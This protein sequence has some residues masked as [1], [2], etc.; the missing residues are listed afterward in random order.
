MHIICFLFVFFCLAW[1]F[2]DS[3]MLLHIA[4]AHSFS[5]F[6]LEF[7]KSKNQLG[8][9]FLGFTVW[10]VFFLGNFCLIQGHKYF[11]PMASF[12]SVILSGFTFRF[13]I[14]LEIIFV[15]D[16]Q[17]WLKLTFFAGRYPVVPKLFIEKNVS[18]PLNCLCTFVENQ[19]TTYICEFIFGLFILIH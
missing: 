8:K 18:S 4:R 17:Y 10:G 5:S 3:F 7:H 9:D 13:M 11:S 19:S 12:R 1:L 6:W 15:C 2:W 16:V 14:H